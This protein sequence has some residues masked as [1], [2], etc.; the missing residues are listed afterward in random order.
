MYRFNRMVEVVILC[1]FFCFVL[2]CVFTTNISIGNDREQTIYCMLLLMP[3]VLLRI[4]IFKVVLL[5]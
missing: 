4:P 2:F 5:T 3:R 1:L